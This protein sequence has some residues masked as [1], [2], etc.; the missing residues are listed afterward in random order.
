MVL[1][2]P[3]F[4]FDTWQVLLIFY[5]IL[6]LTLVISATMNKFLPMVDTLC[7]VFT[8]VT[9]FVCLIALSVKAEVGRHSIDYALTHYDKSFSGWG[10]FSFFIGL[11]PSAYTFSALG[12][13]SAIDTLRIR[14]DR[15][16]IMF[17]C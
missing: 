5:L 4:V 12:K 2:H 10:G 14:L 8:L 3:D 13:W 7:A 9:I 1:Y 16:L 17:S 6:L 15:I 11:L